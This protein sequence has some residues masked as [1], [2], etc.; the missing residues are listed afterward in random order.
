MSILNP[1]SAI[2][3]ECEFKVRDFIVL[4]QIYFC[5]IQNNLDIN[6]LENA[7]ITSVSGTHE[8]GRSIDDVAGLY[9]YGRGIEYFPRGL[10]QVFENLK[11]IWIDSGRIKEIHQADLKVFPNL[12]EVYLDNNDIEDVEEGLFDFNPILE[13]ISFYYNKVSYV[14]PKVFSNLKKLKNL[15]FTSNKC[16]QGEAVNSR[17]AVQ[18][19]IKQTQNMCQNNNGCDVENK[20]RY[21]LLEINASN[22]SEEDE[23]YSRLSNRI[24]KIE[25]LISMLI[26]KLDSRAEDV[27]KNKLKSKSA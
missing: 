4:K 14:H 17:R 6:S 16:I 8:K 10:E 21:D 15:W 9:T 25:N 27:E 2:N 3:I 20:G 24:E 12:V 26:D 13:G 5:E 19:L 22:D 23:K 1:S 11:V 7:N 18:R